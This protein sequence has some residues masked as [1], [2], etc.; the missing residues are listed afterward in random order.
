MLFYSF[1]DINCG[2]IFLDSTPKAKE[3]KGTY[4]NLQS[5]AQQRKQSTKGKDNPLKVK[6]FTN[7]V[8][9]KGLISKI[10][11]KLI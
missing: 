11:K 6:I 2:N 8:I 3:I 7:D 4:S 1:S 9:N 5:F 10:Y